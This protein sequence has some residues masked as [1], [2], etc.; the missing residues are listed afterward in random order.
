[1]V[2]L[3]LNLRNKNIFFFMS[4]LGL[5]FAIYQ[6][7][8]ITSSIDIKAMDIFILFLSFIFTTAMFWTPYQFNDKFI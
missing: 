1:M 7:N 3:T 6:I 5:L 8:Y 4:G 2:K